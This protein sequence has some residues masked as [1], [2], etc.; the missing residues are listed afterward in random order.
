MEGVTTCIAVHSLF[1]GKTHVVSMFLFVDSLNFSYS[2]IS[3]LVFYITIFKN[4]TFLCI[5]SCQFKHV[6][7]WEQ[8]LL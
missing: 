8:Y 1:K 6:N 5:L 4:I 7:M 3:K 2:N